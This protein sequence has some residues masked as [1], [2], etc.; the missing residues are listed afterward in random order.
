MMW[1]AAY[2]YVAGALS[3]FVAMALMVEDEKKSALLFVAFVAIWPVTLPALSGYAV[4]EALRDEYRAW[5]AR[6][7]GAV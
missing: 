7:A 5:R 4:I 3:T 6:R 2:L 1:I